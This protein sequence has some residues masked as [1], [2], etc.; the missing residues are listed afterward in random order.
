LSNPTND[1]QKVA[2]RTDRLLAAMVSATA[3]IVYVLTLAPTVSFWDSGEYITCSWVMGIPHPPGVPFFVLMGRFSTLIFGFIPEVAARVNLLCG[4]AGVVSVGLITRLVQRWCNRLH[5]ESAFY[6]PVSVTAGLLAAFSYTIWRNNNSTETY[7]MA[8]MLSMLILWVFD[9][10]IERRLRGVAAGRHLLLAG[11]LMALSIGN[12]LSALI[13]VGPIALMYILYAFRGWAHE[14]RKP[15]FILGFSGLMMLAFSVHLYMPIRALQQPEVNETNPSRFTEFRDALE[16]KQYGQVSIF[17]RKGPF[18]EQLALFGEYHSWQVGRPEAWQRA[19]GQGGHIPGTT[20]WIVMSLAGLLGLLVLGA[21]RPDLLLLVGGTFFMASFAFVVYLNFKTGPEGTLLGEV[22]ERDYFFGAS[23]AISA[24][25]VAIGGGTVVRFLGGRRSIWAL[26][27]IP[28]TA[29]LVNWHFCDRSGDFVARDYGVNLLQSCAPN[30]ILITNG[31]NDTF[32][33][34]FAQ[35]VLGVRRDVVVSNLSLMNTPWYTHQLMARDSLLLSYPDSLVD[36]LR[37]VFIWGPNFF[38]V[39]SEGMPETDITDRQ[40]LDLTF[41]GSWPWNVFA[42]DICIAVPSMG[43]G[44]QGSLAMQDLLL[45][46]MIKRVPIHGR[47]VYLAG[48]VS[49]DNRV[50]VEDYLLMEGIAYRVMDA[51]QVSEIDP[52]KSWSLVN[53]YLYTGLQDPGVYKDDQAAQ[54]ARNYMGAW[55]ALA[56]HFLATGDAQR[57]R[58]AL[59]GGAAI[60]SAMPEEWMLIMPLHIY[61]EARLVGGVDGPEAASGYLLAMADSLTSGH[62]GAGVRDFSRQ[63]QLLSDELL[64]QGALLQF[65]DSISNGTPVEEWLLIEVEL[66]FG[67][68][69]GARNRFASVQLAYPSDPA[70]LLMSQTLNS[71]TADLS[72]S[73]GIFPQETALAEVLSFMETLPEPESHDITLRMADLASAGRPMTAVCFGSVMASMYPPAGEAALSYSSRILENP[74]DQARLAYWYS[75]ASHS[76]PEGALAGS[77]LRAGLP[78]VAQAL[79]AEGR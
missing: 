10:W 50:Y 3:L 13:V 57:A 37:P 18:A 28:L 21:R 51:P 76:L 67:N 24:I 71:L 15:G 14:W 2:V 5:L 78:E 25:L 69:L 42:G 53:G 1:S 46:D 58:M 73:G 61:A 48:T 22:R 72:T 62:F 12:H 56:N 6:R 23:F 49:R 26:L 63:L 7:A 27:L 65:A 75:M 47:P 16:R 64:Q 43:L 77:C 39:S 20:L 70:L 45:L 60:F 68:F 4:L 11:Y 19:L 33:L 8:L 79:A 32:P 38:H 74:A 54:I 40:I 35:G 34:W 59:D 30:A 66:A 44:S 41:S 9:M 29:L 31:D 36:S 52:E 55:N 17:E